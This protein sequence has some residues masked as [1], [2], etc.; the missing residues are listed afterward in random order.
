MGREKK[1]GRIYNVVDMGIDLRRWYM[2]IFLQKITELSGQSRTVGGLVPWQVFGTRDDS[3]ELV[4]G[5]FFL[6]GWQ[7]IPG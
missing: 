3:S 4:Y 1:G 2:S 5:W 7:R 6:R